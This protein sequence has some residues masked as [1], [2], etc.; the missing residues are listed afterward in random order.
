M[1]L[2]RLEPPFPASLSDLFDLNLP[3]TG[4]IRPPDMRLEPG[5]TSTSYSTSYVAQADS[6]ALKSLTASNS[7][8]SNLMA[9]LT[10]SLNFGR[11]DEIYAYLWL[12]GR[13]TPAR[14]LHRQLMRQRQITITEQTDLHL[15]WLQTRFFVKPLFRELLSHSMWTAHLCNDQ[16]LHAAASG[17]LLSWIWIIKG[18]SDFRIAHDLHLIPDTLTWP[19]LCALV[20]HV[21]ERVDSVSLQG[22]HPRYHYGELRMTRLNIIWRVLHPTSW[23]RSFGPSYDRYSTY[24]TNNFAWL[25]LVVVFIGLNL[26]AMQVGLG[27]DSLQVSAAFQRAALTLVVLT[28]IGELTVVFII[29]LI[30]IVTAS[31]HVHSARSFVAEVRE[32]RAK[33]VSRSG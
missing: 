11:F 33:G 8:P 27:L 22:V 29:F 12:A 30:I 9:F 4:Q 1:P 13:P 23:Y 19:M 17:F 15:T 5:I 31:W 14:P 21:L 24:L 20:R 7:D 6:T 26:S 10:D 3:A 18:E 2:V 25:A 28:T 16:S 32:R